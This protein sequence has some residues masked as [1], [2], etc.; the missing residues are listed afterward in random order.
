MQR[1]NALE[2][3]CCKSRLVEIYFIYQIFCH[4][5]VHATLSKLCLDFSDDAVKDMYFEFLWVEERDP[6]G[7]SLPPNVEVPLANPLPI[8]K[9]CRMPLLC[10][11][12]QKVLIAGIAQLLTEDCDEFSH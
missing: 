12:I 4:L 2:K 11:Y 1:N 9:K 7:G 10:G 3:D 8:K 5:P 6:S